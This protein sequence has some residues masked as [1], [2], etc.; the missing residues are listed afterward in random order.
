MTWFPDK[1]ICCHQYP[2]KRNI[3]CIIDIQISRIFLYSSLL[4]VWTFH[5]LFN[6]ASTLEYNFHLVVFSEL[7]KAHIIYIYIYISTYSTVSIKEYHFSSSVKLYDYILLITF[8][9]IFTTTVLF[10]HLF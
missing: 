5:E 6:T 7:V 8:K 4:V 10:L 1:I 2:L 3:S 9:P